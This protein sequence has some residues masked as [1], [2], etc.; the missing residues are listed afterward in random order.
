MA[1]AP[2][3]GSVVDNKYTLE[4]V[5]GE[6]GMGVVYL[7]RDR[8]IGTE[9]VLKAVRTELAHRSDVRDRLLAEGKALARIDH[10]NVVRFNAVIV[11]GSALWLVMQFVDGESLDVTIER[12]AQQ[13]ARMHLGEALRLFR[14]IVEGVGAAHQEGLIHRD[15]KPANVLVRRKDGVAKVGD[16]GIVKHE[17]DVAQGKGATRGTIGSLW[18]MS[19][20]QVLGLRDL[21]RRVDI[22]A[23]GIVLYEMLIGRV[24]FDAASDFELMRLQAEAPMPSLLAER[25]ELPPRL[26]EIVQRATA[27]D[28]ERRF[29]SCE[30]LLAALTAVDASPLP[31]SPTQAMLEP[32]P[33]T[34]METPPPPGGYVASA[35]T[36]PGSSSVTSSTDAGLPTWTPSPPTFNGMT[37]AAAP[38]HGPPLASSNPGRQNT[39]VAIAGVGSLVAVAT[40]IA[41][42]SRSDGAGTRTTNDAARDDRGTASPGGSSSVGRE[43]VKPQ[44]PALAQVA[45]GWRSVETQR[46]FDA[47]IVGDSVEFRIVEGQ[48]FNVVYRT[49]DVR[50]ALR[51]VVGMPG[52]YTVVDQPRVPPPPNMTATAEARATCVATIEAVDGKPLGARLEGK[53]LAVETARFEPKLGNFSA[54]GSQVT[55]CVGLAALPLTRLP[56][57]RL[58][59]R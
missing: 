16:F 52:S 58:T 26:D 46:D 49:G 23:L 1:A 2:T 14:Q 19:P 34:T 17:A 3:L 32:P 27:K 31:A 25:P 28:R 54:S 10:P 12:L 35:L 48:Q 59:R 38:L 36:T 9:V 4:R 15:L 45:G 41:L 53:T 22:Y 47:V 30:Q 33:R 50:F 37:G 40:L 21:D 51:P 5:L 42:S 20:E 57:L 24:P 39:L 55:S 7:A 43:A 13:G 6:G 29:A 44:E 11:E 56:A 8:N 18:Y